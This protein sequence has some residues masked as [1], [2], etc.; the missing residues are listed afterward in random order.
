MLKSLLKLIGLLRGFIQGERD[1]QL[2]RG[3]YVNNYTP[4][5]YGTKITWRK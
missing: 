1:A 5:T 3:L 2:K 4:K